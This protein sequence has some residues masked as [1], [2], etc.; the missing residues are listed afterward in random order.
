M[1]AKSRRKQLTELNSCSLDLMNSCEAGAASHPERGDLRRR[2]GQFGRT[3]MVTVATS[4]VRVP[5]LT[6]K[7]NVSVPLNP[8]FGV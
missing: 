7:V 8:A 4:D 5:S 3:V 6:R 1:H 2:L